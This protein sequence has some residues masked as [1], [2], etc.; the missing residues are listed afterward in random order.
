MSP[1][2]ELNHLIGSSI[3][4]AQDALHSFC[5]MNGYSLNI[6][7]PEFNK[8]SIMKDSRCLNVMTDSNGIIKTIK[9]G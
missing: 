7:D 6:Q 8:Y 4:D 1:T 5:S 3:L 2:S 9:L